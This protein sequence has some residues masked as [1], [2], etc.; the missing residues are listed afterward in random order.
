MAMFKHIYNAVVVFFS[1][2]AIIAFTKQFRDGKEDESK[3]PSQADL[4]EKRQELEAVSEHERKMHEMLKSN[5]NSDSTKEC[6]SYVEYR[7]GVL[8][9]PYD[10]RYDIVSNDQLSDFKVSLSFKS[11]KFKRDISFECKLLYQ[12]ATQHDLASWTVMS[13][14]FK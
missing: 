14:S 12:P 3:S 7:K 4:F 13:W 2:V 1:V 5:L 8:D 10:A 9:I 11:E 6:R